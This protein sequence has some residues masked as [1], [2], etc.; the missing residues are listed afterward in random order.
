[1]NA[2]EIN[3]KRKEEEQINDKE[4]GE[5]LLYLSRYYKKIGQIDK[6][7]ELSRRLLDLQGI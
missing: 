2:F 1:M 7:I 6:A 4:T 5:C 3:L